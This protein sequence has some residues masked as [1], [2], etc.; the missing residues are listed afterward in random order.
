MQEEFRPIIGS[1]RDIIYALV[2]LIRDDISHPRSVKDALKALF[3]ICLW[4]VNR[5]NVF[6]FCL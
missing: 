6:L 2:D 4:K 1:K 3:G 5:G